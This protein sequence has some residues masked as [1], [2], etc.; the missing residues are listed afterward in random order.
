MV[1]QAIAALTISKDVGSSGVASWTPAVII[2]GCALLFTV[3]S[4]WWLNARRG[5]LK[6]FEPHTFSA[7]ITQDKVRLVLPLVFHNTGAIPIIIQSFRIRFLDERDSIPMPWV[8]TRPQVMPQKDDWTFPAVFAVGGRS[9]YQ[10]FVEFGAPG[11]PGFLFNAKDYQVCLEAK[12]S[13]RKKWRHILNFTLH[14]A[15]IVDPEH[16]ITYENSPV[17]L[18]ED[19]RKEVQLGLDFAQMG[20]GPKPGAAT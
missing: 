18:S 6:S 17:Y 13:H 11:A 1:R 14:A 8:T 7:A 4:F 20:Q 19:E 2:A 9:A 15:Q 12:L 3:G 16:Y 5:R 10:T